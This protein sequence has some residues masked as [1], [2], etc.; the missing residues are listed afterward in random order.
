MNI[1]KILT[2]KKIS[3]SKVIMKITAEDALYSINEALEDFSLFV[4][5][6]KFSKEELEKLLSDYADAVF[7]YHGKITIEREPHL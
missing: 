5:F 2:S 4:D 3:P 7:I 6:N 1:S